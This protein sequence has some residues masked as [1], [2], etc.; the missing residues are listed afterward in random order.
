MVFATKQIQTRYS[1]PDLIQKEIS[2]LVSL[3]TFP[4]AAVLIGWVSRFNE[5]NTSLAN[6]N[7]IA[8]LHDTYA[9]QSIVLT[10]AMTTGFCSDSFD[11]HRAGEPFSARNKE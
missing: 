5:F 9:E 4:G 3:L 2:P 7:P 11:R 8:I 1:L 10:L 6:E